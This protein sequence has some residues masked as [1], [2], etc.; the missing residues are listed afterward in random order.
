MFGF[1]RAT[2]IYLAVRVKLPS[3][4]HI[5]LFRRLNVNLLHT[6]LLEFLRA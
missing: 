1:G 3:S 5:D 4:P 2:R 6:N